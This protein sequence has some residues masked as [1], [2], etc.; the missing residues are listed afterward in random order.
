L[1]GDEISKEPIFSYALLQFLQVATTWMPFIG[2]SACLAFDAF[3]L[4]VEDFHN[5]AKSNAQFPN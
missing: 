1:A 4:S 2:V 3:V 5:V